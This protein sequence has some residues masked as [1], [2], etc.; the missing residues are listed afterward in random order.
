MIFVVVVVVC[1]FVC[2]FLPQAENAQSEFAHNDCVHVAAAWCRLIFQL[3][4]RK[5]MMSVFPG[6]SY[7]FM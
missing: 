5:Y 7:C 6:I 4:Q 2:L 1:L 3:S